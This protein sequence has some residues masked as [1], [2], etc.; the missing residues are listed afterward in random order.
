[1]KIVGRD[2]IQRRGPPAGSLVF[3]KQPLLPLWMVSSIKYCWRGTATCFT[4][5]QSMLNTNKPIYQ[6]YTFTCLHHVLMKAFLKRWLSSVCFLSVY[7]IIH[8]VLHNTPW[9]RKRKHPQDQT[10]TQTALPGFSCLLTDLISK[11]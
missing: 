5:L 8:N 11:T 9:T 10:D 7:V 4:A 6:I 1:M 2:S 3:G